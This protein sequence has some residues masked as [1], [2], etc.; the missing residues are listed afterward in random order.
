M[1]DRA[2]HGTNRNIFVTGRGIRERTKIGPPIKILAIH[3]WW[4]LDDRHHSPAEP[5]RAALPAL[6]HFQKKKSTRDIW[7]NE[8]LEK[9]LIILL[10]IYNYSWTWI[11]LLKKCTK[12]WCKA[13]LPLDA[14][15]RLCSACQTRDRENQR[16]ALQCARQPEE[17]GNEVRKKQ[18]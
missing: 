16:A 5:L 7:F 11:M 6:W 13:I 14:T 4:C 10:I 1:H 18:L 8:N 9:Y 3:I 15:K 17:E 2:S 12:P